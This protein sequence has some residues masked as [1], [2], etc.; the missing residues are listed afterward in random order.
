[1]KLLPKLILILLSLVPFAVGF[2]AGIFWVAATT[3]FQNYVKVIGDF[4]N[5]K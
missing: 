5:G 1:M 3:G 4:H 2:L